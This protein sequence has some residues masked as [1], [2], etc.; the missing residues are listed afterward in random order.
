[1]K[2]WLLDKIDE[3]WDQIDYY[4]LYCNPCL[5]ACADYWRGRLEAFE[6]TYEAMYGY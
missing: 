4:E 6:S 3:C 1:M 5:S 2:D